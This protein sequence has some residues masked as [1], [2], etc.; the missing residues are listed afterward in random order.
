MLLARVEGGP[1]EGRIAAYQA[2]AVLGPSSPWP[3]IA[4]GTARAELAR[5]LQGRAEGRERAGYAEEA[6]AL[7]AEARAAAER[8]CTEAERAVALAPDLA[9][10]QAALAHALGVAA[11]LT[12]GG[13]AE[14]RL[15]RARAGECWDRSLAIDPG[16][17]RVLLGR[18]L[19]RRDAGRPAEAQGDLDAA[20]RAAPRDPAVLSIRARNLDDQG[21]QAEAARAW[22]AAV[23]AAPADA[24][25]RTDFASSLAR[26]GRWEEALGAWRKADALFA[27]SGGERWKARRGLATGLAQLGLERKDPALLAEA[28]VQLRAY[29]AEGGPDASWAAR[30]GEVLGEEAEA[31]GR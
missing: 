5:D 7:R 27:G 8:A 9:A 6:E 29:R 18:A 17:P 31:S 4:L 21:L 19:L 13:D 15:L 3:R 28:L 30:L 10:S 12:A 1:A 2:A 26:A 11:S 23:R 14:R 20:A 22:E 24:E 16:D 25:V